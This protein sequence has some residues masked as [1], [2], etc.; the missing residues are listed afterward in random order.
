[1]TTEEAT[2]MGKMIATLETL[3][4]HSKSYQVMNPS[5]RAAIMKTISEAKAICEGGK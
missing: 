3:M 4:Y 5:Q 2:V 1:M